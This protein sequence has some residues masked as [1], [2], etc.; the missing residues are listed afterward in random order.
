[1]ASGELRC[2][3]EE[4]FPC[5][6]F[7]WF[8]PFIRFRSFRPFGW[9]AW[10]A[11]VYWVYIPPVLTPNIPSFQ[12]SIDPSAH[13]PSWDVP[14]G[15]K[16]LSS[17]MINSSLSPRNDQISLKVLQFFFA[18]PPDLHQFLNFPKAPLL[19]SILDDPLCQPGADA[20]NECQVFFLYLIE[21]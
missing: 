9:F 3:Y 11:R 2:P 13:Y 20:G 15:A 18:D 19:R 21:V 5:I 4:S 12:H 6:W 8:I 1:M 14:A 16:P 7:I 17:D 10:V